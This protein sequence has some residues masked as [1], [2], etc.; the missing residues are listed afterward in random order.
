MFGEIPIVSEIIKTVLPAIYKIIMF[1]Q[2]KWLDAFPIFPLSC[3]S[4][5]DIGFN[6]S[7]QSLTLSQEFSSLLS[8][9]MSSSNIFS[10]SLP[11]LILV[12]RHFT[13]I[14]TF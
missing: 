5:L 8:P 12:L 13:N 10:V 6:L 4:F 3:V 14:L 9:Y 1:R 2:V 11:F 7:T